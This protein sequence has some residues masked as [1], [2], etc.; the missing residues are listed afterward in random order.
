MK[1]TE[2]FKKLFPTAEVYWNWNINQL[3]LHFMDQEIDVSEVEVKV[4]TELSFAGLLNA[5]EI[6]RILSY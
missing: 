1:I 2:R 3:S 4:Y 5:V 6:V